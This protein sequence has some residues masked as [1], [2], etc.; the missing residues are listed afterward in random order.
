MPQRLRDHLQ[1]LCQ[2]Q[3]EAERIKYEASFTLK[4]RKSLGT[5]SAITR[6]GIIN[7]TA[8]LVS[9]KEELLAGVRSVRAHTPTGA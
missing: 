6:D 5:K 1:Q 4:F 8:R 7:L 3:E 2:R 9:T